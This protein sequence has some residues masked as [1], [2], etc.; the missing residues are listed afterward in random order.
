LSALRE[1]VKGFLGS[2]EYDAILALAGREKRLVRTAIS[3]LYDGDE[4]TRWRAVTFMGRLALAAPERIPPLLKRFIWWMNDESGGIGWGSAPAMGEIGRAAPELMQ[5]AVRVVVHYRL[6]RFL[7]PGVI[8]ATGRLA[9]TFPEVVAEA[10]PDLVSFLGDDDKVVRGQAVLA[11]GEIGDDR[12][13]EGLERLLD[14]ESNV[15]LYEDEMLSTKEVKTAAAEALK[16]ISGGIS[17][18]EDI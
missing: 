11:L 10:V 8:W 5:G 12:A 7:F 9:K 17:C 15:S 3:L 14:D 16:K 2:R 6:E 13:R 4:L 1:S 18:R